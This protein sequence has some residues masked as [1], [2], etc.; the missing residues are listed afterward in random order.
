MSECDDVI[1]QIL[2]YLEGTDKIEIATVESVTSLFLTSDRS[3]NE[4]GMNLNFILTLWKQY[5][6]FI[7]KCQ[8]LIQFSHF[9]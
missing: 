4:N 3:F 8:D 1:A 2:R 7:K 6:P 5:L 9:Q